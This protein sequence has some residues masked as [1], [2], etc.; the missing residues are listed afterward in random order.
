MSVDFKTVQ[1]GF[2]AHLRNP[3]KNA[4]PADVEDRR[5]GIYRD[6]FFNN[7]QGFIANSFPVVRKLHTKDQWERLIRKFFSQ[8]QSHTPLFP[9][10]P[11]EFLQFLDDHPPEQPFL[12]ELAH[13]EWAELAVQLD[14]ADLDDVECDPEGDL[15]DHVPVKSPLAWLL[16]YQY[17]VHR[18]RP[19]YQPSEPS[20]EPHYL[21]VY[22]RRDDKV[23]FMELNAVTAKLLQSLETHHQL[24]GDEHLVSLAQALSVPADQ[25][26]ANGHRILEDF[27]ERQIIL[28]STT[29]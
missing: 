21:V 19:D 20:D 6:L 11:R 13:Y 27:R 22:R 12:W 1:Y 9:E 7:I 23:R 29:Q 14:E 17:P 26:R 4:P 18:I 2:A 8:H 15:L 24:T 28:G 10:L 25:I 5:M 16:S 3:E